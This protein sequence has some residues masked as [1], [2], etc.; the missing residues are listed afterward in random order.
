MEN[1]R[2]GRKIFVQLQNGRIATM[3]SQQYQEYLKRREKQAEENNSQE[4]AAAA[5][6]DAK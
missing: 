2:K 3:T 4:T 1:S 5:G 6:E